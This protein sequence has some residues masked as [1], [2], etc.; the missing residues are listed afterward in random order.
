M[1][2]P[3]VLDPTGGEGLFSSTPV[4]VV[5]LEVVSQVSVGIGHACALAGNV[6]CYG[7]GQSGELGHDGYQSS[8]VPVA[9]TLPSVRAVSVGGLH[10]CALVADG[11]VWCWDPTRRGRSATAPTPSPARPNGSSAWVP[12]AELPALRSP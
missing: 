1:I 7:R 12:S 9:V 10:T 11:S 4:D 6:W 2:S 5:G 8:N 3:V